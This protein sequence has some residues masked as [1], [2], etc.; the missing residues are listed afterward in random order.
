MDK[1]GTVL[2]T[3][4]VNIGDTVLVDPSQYGKDKFDSETH[5]AVI[6]GNKVIQNLNIHTSCSVA[7]EVGDQHGGVVISSFTPDGSGGKGKGSKG[8]GSK[9]KDS[10]AKGS[11]GKGSKSKDKGSKGKGPKSKGSKGKK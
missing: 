1:K 7:L 3:E 11:K 6:S 4:T 5:I 10:K 9:G 2:L 8:K